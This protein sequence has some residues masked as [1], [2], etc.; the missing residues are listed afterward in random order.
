[1]RDTGKP[2]FSVFE[3]IIGDTTYVVEY[4]TGDHAKESACEKLKRLILNSMD[5]CVQTMPVRQIQSPS[6]GAVS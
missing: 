6:Y 5:E 4:M 2:I 1:M 3:K